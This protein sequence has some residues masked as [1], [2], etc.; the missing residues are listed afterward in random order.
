MVSNNDVISINTLLK[1]VLYVV[2]MHARGHTV[3]I[4][5]SLNNF[6]QPDTVLKSGALN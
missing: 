2:D 1:K 5:V 3:H 4:M 6:E